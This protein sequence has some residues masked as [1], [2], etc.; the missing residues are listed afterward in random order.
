[1]PLRCPKGTR[2]NKKTGNCEA[3]GSPK[4][5]TAKMK[6]TKEQKE[7][8]PICLKPMNKNLIETHCKHTFHEKCLKQQCYFNPS[9][10][11][12][13]SNI[14]KECKMKPP[15]LTTQEIKTI[16]EKFVDVGLTIEQYTEKINQPN[17]YKEQ[18]WLRKQL[19]NLK[20]DHDFNT[21]Y[22]QQYGNTLYHQAEQKVVYYYHNGKKDIFGERFN[23]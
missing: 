9:C 3:K 7:E 4:N 11:L 19:K 16:V 12:C 20:Y 1:M 22:T 8:C 18:A 5:K 15:K 13:R 14:S 10:P 23:P 17:F 2:R 21:P 6:P